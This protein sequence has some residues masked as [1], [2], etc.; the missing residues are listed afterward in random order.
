MCTYIHTRL[1]V[2]IIIESN[3]HV[4]M[5][6][7]AIKG[8]KSKKKKKL[9]LELG[10]C[11]GGLSYLNND[12]AARPFEQTPERDRENEICEKYDVLNNLQ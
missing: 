9:L 1:L 3:N 4:T 11:Q 10:R 5:R 12:G 8:K 7:K 2:F 6:K